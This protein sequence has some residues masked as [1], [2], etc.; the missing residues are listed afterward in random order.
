M[1]FFMKSMNVSI[2]STGALRERIYV[3]DVE[4][5]GL[6]DST[7]DVSPTPSAYCKS[8][9]IR[10]QGIGLLKR[11]EVSLK[12]Y[13]KTQ[14]STMYNKLVRLGSEFTIKLGTFGGGTLNKTFTTYDFSFEM[15]RLGGF[16]VIV[17]GLSKG[18]GPG[19]L[20]DEIDILNQKY[21]DRKKFV[22]NYQG[23]NDEAY[24]G[25]FFDHI[26]YMCQ[27]KT[28]QLSGWLT[29]T[30]N[31]PGDGVNGYNESF[32][33][34]IGGQNCSIIVAEMPNLS[35][36]TPGLIHPGATA[37]EDVPANFIKLQSLVRLVNHYCVKGTAYT[38][39]DSS[40]YCKVKKFDGMISSDPT[41]VCWKFGANGGG[42]GKQDTESMMGVNS[43]EAPSDALKIYVNM[44]FIS[45]IIAQ[46]QQA[47]NEDSNVEAEDRESGRLPMKKFF[48]QIFGVIRQCTG[49][50]V[51]LTLDVPEDESDTI[52]IVNKNQDYDKTSSPSGLAISLPGST[53]GATSGI[54]DVSL[55]G[56][57]P[58]SL[59]AK[60]FGNAPDSD[61]TANAASKVGTGITSKDPAMT[62]T[63][64]Q[65]RDALIV[66]GEAGFDEAS[67]AGLRKLVNI[68][69]NEQFK[70]SAKLDPPPIPLE[71]S[72]VTNGCKNWKFGGVVTVSGLPGAIAGSDRLIWTVSEWTQIADGV[73]WKTEVKCIPRILK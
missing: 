8:F 50:W 17:K 44:I 12:A 33:V 47:L 7:S 23:F 57:I 24:T 51:D 30:M 39:S 43:F 3:A 31:D 65:F 6:S 68:R 4:G 73:D 71:L 70:D 69:A 14:F 42:Y 5:Y 72:F 61:G 59:T 45:N 13:N 10:T 49:N 54:R 67:R 16:D 53:G 48:D 32:G 11:A 19:R 66:M 27:L 58:S 22:I 38:L 20:Y 63:S 37:N 29:A 34:R 62:A 64:A 60:Y 26:H 25:T 9:K 40:T 52:Y 2:P 15:D 36:E 21:T 41:A 1:S 46:T 18:E 28:S 55:T 35:K 56:A